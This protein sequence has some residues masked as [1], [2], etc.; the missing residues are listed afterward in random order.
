M[1]NAQYED[2]YTINQRA[3]I[4]HKLFDGDIDLRPSEYDLL[5]KYSSVQSDV[6]RNGNLIQCI[7]FW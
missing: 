6:S 2:E 3:G 7:E 4:A 5:Q 1:R